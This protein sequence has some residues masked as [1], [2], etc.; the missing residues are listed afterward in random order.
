MMKKSVVLKSM[1]TRTSVQVNRYIPGV[2]MSEIDFVFDATVAA[3]TDIEKAIA[4]H[5]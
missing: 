2:F 5:A 3:D 4:I 1:S